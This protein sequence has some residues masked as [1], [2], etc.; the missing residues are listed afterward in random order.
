MWKNAV[1]RDRPSMTICLMRITCWIP[2]A[3]NTHT[4]MGCVILVAR[5]PQQCLYGRPSMLRYTFS[6]CR[7]THVGCCSHVWVPTPL[8]Q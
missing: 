7:V 5:L 6:A 1:K 8:E 3:T 4:H 2:K